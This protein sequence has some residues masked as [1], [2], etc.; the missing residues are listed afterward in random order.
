MLAGLVLLAVLLASI[1]IPLLTAAATLDRVDV[2]ALAGGPG[3]VHTLVVGSDARDDM[4]PEQQAE[5]GTGSTDGLRTD[6]LFVLSVDGGRA[7]ILA[8]PRDLWVTRC[9]GSNGRINGAYGIG[10]PDCLVETVQNLT[11]LGIDHYLEV[12]FL[13]F[14]DL[15]GA[16]GGVEVCLDKPIEDPFAAIDLPAGCQVLEGRD[17]LG[18]VRVRKIDNDLERIKRQQG[19][20]SALADR[21]LQPSTLLNPFRATAT[22]RAAGNALTVDSGLGLGDLVRLARGGRGLASGRF[23]ATTVPVTDTTI[24]GASVL[25]QIDEPA[26]AL[27]L[28][29]IDGSIFDTIAPPPAEGEVPSGEEPT[30]E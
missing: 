26:Q 2:P 24:N 27:Y 4:T 29:F 3:P 10:G 7:A 14:V 25:L 19:F 28:S 22:A 12:D 5:L 20:V 18:Y 1:M 6:T 9:D 15:V 21:I 8:L 13:G 17:A 16:V 30:T 11:G 23:V